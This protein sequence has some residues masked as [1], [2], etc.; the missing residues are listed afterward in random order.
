MRSAMIV[1]FFV[2]AVIYAMPGVCIAAGHALLI[3]VNGS[4]GTNLNIALKGPSH[5]VAA[6][7][8]LLVEHYAFHDKNI[9]AL[10]GKSALR[11]TILKELVKL[12]ER[13]SKGD[14]IFLFF[15]GHGSSPCDLSLNLPSS[16]QD[17]WGTGS[18]FTGGLLPYDFD[19]T[20]PLETMIM[21]K[22]DL[23]PIISELDKKCHVFAV[24][25][26]CYSQDTVRSLESENRSGVENRSYCRVKYRKIKIPSS[27]RG[28]MLDGDEGISLSLEQ[29]DIKDDHFENSG[30]SPYKNTVYLAASGRNEEAEDIT[31]TQPPFGFMTVDGNP[32]GV[33][34]NSLLKALAYK[35]NDA[36]GDGKNGISYGELFEYV[37]MDIHRNHFRQTP[38][39]LLPENPSLL[40]DTPVFN[41]GNIATSSHHNGTGNGENYQEA[42]IPDIHSILRIKIEKS[43]REILEDIELIKNIEPVQDKPDMIVVKT[44]TF[45]QIGLPS[46]RIV[47]EYP[48]AEKGRLIKRIERETLL[49]ALK[50]PS[51][52]NRGITVYAKL[53]TDSATLVSGESI[54]MEWQ[55]DHKSHIFIINIDSEGF[56]NVLYPSKD[57]EFEPQAPNVIKRVPFFGRVTESGMGYELLQ[58]YAFLEKPYGMEKFMDKSLDPVGDSVLYGNMLKMIRHGMEVG[59]ARTTIYFQ[60][61]G[62]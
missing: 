10:T 53:L 11:A 36:N 3:G 60:T 14:N 23:R 55:A 35:K 15:S 12:K 18:P 24:F 47:K 48:V 30:I 1:F 6:L 19:E 17:G 56:I 28:S 50:N 4:E 37:R 2:C 42:A 9:I 62:E 34:T 45:W 33:L 7:K 8:K 38:Q 40:L 39:S 58:V 22:R 52:F 21:G 13:A 26:A 44:G 49:Y 51:F 27:S 20:R 43:A 16:I 46:G 57:S 5:D 59:L 61:C 32:H 31:S 54:G 41:T 29:G 25:D